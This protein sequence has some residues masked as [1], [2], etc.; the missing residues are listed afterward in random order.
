MVTV[1]LTPS[2]GRLRTVTCRPAGPV[3]A[4]TTVKPRVTDTLSSD[5]VTRRSAGTPVTDTLVDR[6]PAGTGDGTALM[7]V[8]ETPWIVT[9]P[10]TCRLGCTVSSARTWKT[11]AREPARKVARAGSTAGLF[12]VMIMSPETTVQRMLRAGAGY[13]ATGGGVCATTPRPPVAV[14]SAATAPAPGAV[15][16]RLIPVSMMSGKP[17]PA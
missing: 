2:A 11:P 15:G 14:V 13:G 4:G 16:A 3:A 9:G 5:H 1:P 7:F 8:S 17:L 12:A 6:S 10:T